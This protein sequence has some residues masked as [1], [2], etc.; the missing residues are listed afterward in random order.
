MVYPVEH[1][2]FTWASTS[3][4]IQPSKPKSSWN[5]SAG[6]SRWPSCA[7]SMKSA[8]IWSATGAPSEECLGLRRVRKLRLDRTQ[9]E[10][11]DTPRGDG[12]DRSLE[13]PHG[14]LLLREPRRGVAFVDDDPVVPGG[15]A[16][17][18]VRQLI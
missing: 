9:E 14:E 12:R 10:I 4:T 13:L 1:G 6:T 15:I 11:R 17:R 18:H 2:R 16:R 3:S 7:A 8:P 5:C